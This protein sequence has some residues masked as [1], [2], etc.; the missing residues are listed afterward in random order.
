MIKIRNLKYILIIF[1]SI[2]LFLVLAVLT[3]WGLLHLVSDAPDR[4]TESWQAVTISGLGTFRV[5]AE[6][7]VEQYDGILYITDRPREYGDYTI[8]IVGATRESGIQPY[9]VF[10]DVKRNNFLHSLGGFNNGA[11]ISLVEY[12][13]NG[14][15]QEHH[16]ISFN[17][18]RMNASVFYSLF[19][20][21]REGVDEWTAVQI[22]R[23][24]SPTRENF[25]D[26]S[27][28]LLMP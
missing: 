11:S 25:D 26:Y 17:N 6:W 20:W 19:V 4:I 9:E 3:L 22:A 2:I 28:G 13:V 5:P 8:Y 21:N 14:M 18:M 24:F 10:D 27:I 7:N 16:F 23:T 15:K 1:G 12:T